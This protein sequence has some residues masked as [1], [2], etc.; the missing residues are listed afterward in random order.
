[1]Y[2]CADAHAQY[3][4][5]AAIGKDDSGNFR[6]AACKEY[7]PLFSAGLARAIVDQLC[8]DRRHGHLRPCS[9]TL[10]ETALRQWVFEAAQDSAVIY[11]SST[12]LPDYQGV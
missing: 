3:P 2:A 10:D 12:F 7:P 11:D 1:M 6:T 9:F 5:G 4:C 8:T